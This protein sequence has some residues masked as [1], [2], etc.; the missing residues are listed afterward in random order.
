M[1]TQK[2][3]I[4][5]L[6]GHALRFHGI[7]HFIGWASHWQQLKQVIMYVC[8]VVHFITQMELGEYVPLTSPFSTVLKT[9]YRCTLPL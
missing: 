7:S 9:T 5:S 8:H 3:A 4:F 2:E 6:I 1:T